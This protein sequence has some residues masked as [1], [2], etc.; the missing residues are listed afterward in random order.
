MNPLS[1]IT[2][3]ARDGTPLAFSVPCAYVDAVRAA[4]ATPFVLPAGE[5]HPAGLLDHVDGVLLSGGGDISPA[6]YGRELH[7]AVYAVCEER[8]ESEFG[9]TR[10]VLA[11][12][13][14]PL[15][16]ICRGM[17][18]LN[19]VCGGTL[20]VHVPEQF[21][22]DVLHRSPPRLPTQHGARID[23]ES[24]LGRMLGATEVEVCSWHHQ[25]IDRV[26]DRLAA[27]AWA[28]DGVI[29]A[30]E[31]TTHPWCFAVQW[32]PEM[33]MDAPPQRRLFEA[34]IAA[35]GDKSRVSR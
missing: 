19:V 34:F 26:G 12:P 25:A 13:D 9:L 3:Y 17:Q 11:R 21:G 35:A 30:V 2:S 32:H 22:D 27:V 18:V 8:D 23:P 24:R 4:G 31:H 15:L 16:C 29:E 20:H 6:A 14:V 1:A 10:A 28:G 7:E 5:R 33:Q